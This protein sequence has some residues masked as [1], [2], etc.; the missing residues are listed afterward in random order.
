MRMA[1]LTE[2]NRGWKADRS[3]LHDL[4][5]LGG[6]KDHSSNRVSPYFETYPHFPQQS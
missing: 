2:R 3:Q 6:A 4:L 1:H 5:K